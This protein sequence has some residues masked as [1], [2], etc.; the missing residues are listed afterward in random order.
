MPKGS[1][2][3]PESMK[4]VEAANQE[5]A[6]K[7]WKVVKLLPNVRQFKVIISGFDTVF[8]LFGIEKRLPPQMEFKRHSNGKLNRYIKHQFTRM[9]NNCTS[10]PLLF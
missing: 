1:K 7:G 6:H 3:K 2:G 10:N 9:E 8:A 5:K 4:K